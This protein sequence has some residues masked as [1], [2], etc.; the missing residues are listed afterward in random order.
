MGVVA[1]INA[2]NVIQ[3]AMIMRSINFKLKTKV[4]LNATLLSGVAGVA[5]AYYGLGVWSLVIQQISNRFLITVSLWIYST[6]KPAWQ[7]SINS[8][9]RLFSFGF[10]VLT[11]NI[12]RTVFDNIYILTI[13]KFFPMAQL[14]FYTKAK[15]FQELSSKQ[16]SMSIGSV[17]FPVFSQIQDDKLRLKNSMRKFLNHTLVFIA[18]LMVILI[19]VAKPFVL[20]L[21]TSKW[22][23]MI[24]FLQLLCIVGLLHPIHS[25]NVQVLQAQGMSKLNFR[26]SLLKNGLRLLNIIVMFRFGVLFIIVGEIAASV[27]ALL[28]NTFYTKKFVKYGL[29]E[30]LNDIK[31]ITF[32][33]LLSGLSGYMLTYY[34]QNMYLQLLA[35]V[36]FT[37]MM[38][39]VLLYLLDKRFVL[40]LM[41]LKEE[42]LK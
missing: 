23:P 11:A 14:G 20:V 1:I 40:E 3:L 22:A 9:K 16:L 17:S 36:S 7:F 5:S 39:I 29:L 41:E 38:Y 10:W 42:L 24:P 25:L 19:V 27:L 26:L 28:I 2:F 15:S 37:G 8:F 18:P 35:G 32:A 21:L 12:L 4:T 13:G 30:Q 31:A 6:W 33:S 34:I